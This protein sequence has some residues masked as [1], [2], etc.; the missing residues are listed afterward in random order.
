VIKSLYYAK[1]HNLNNNI[2]KTIVIDKDLTKR[3]TLEQNFPSATIFYWKFHCIQNFGRNIPAKF[4]EIHLFLE[5]ETEKEYNK[6]DATNYYQ[7]CQN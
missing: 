6:V 4:E 2:T 5:S 1:Q 7:A 3:N